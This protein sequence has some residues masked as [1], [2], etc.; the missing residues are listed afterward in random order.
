ISVL[1]LALG[2]ILYLVFRAPSA[3][4]LFAQAQRLME[5]KTQD[6]ITQARNGP[7][8][9]YL[10]YYGDRTDGQTRQ[11][12]EWADRYDVALLDQQLEK[13]QRLNLSP[14]G[15]AETHARRPVGFE[16]VG[17]WSG[18]RE[19]W[20]EV[21][22]FKKTRMPMCTYGAFWRR[23]ESRMWPLRRRSKRSC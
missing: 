11:I 3:E 13:R 9:D 12:R 23:R 15:D 2:G 10:E 5:T 18:A 6:N 19:Q 14:E 21:A 1:L 4:Q 17:D 20:S 8:K 16:N 22:K 7:I